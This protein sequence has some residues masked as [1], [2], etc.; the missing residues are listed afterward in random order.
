MGPPQQGRWRNSTVADKD[1]ETAKWQR[2]RDRLGRPL[3]SNFLDWIRRNAAAAK[4]RVRIPR[5]ALGPRASTAF[6]FD[7]GMMG[8]RQSSDDCGV[9]SLAGTLSAARRR[10]RL[11]SITD[12]DSYRL[13][14]KYCFR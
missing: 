10:E 11:L 13:P 14:H 7:S 8:W 2:P 5:G 9:V 6:T 1:R 3:T 12:Q 4:F